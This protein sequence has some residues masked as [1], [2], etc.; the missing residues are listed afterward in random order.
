MR[1]EPVLSPANSMLHFAKYGAK[2]VLMWCPSCNEH[3]DEV[4]TKEQDV[5]FPYEHV[6]SFIAR[7]LDRV[8][9]VRRVERRVALHYHTGSAQSDLDWQNTRAI[10]RRRS[11]VST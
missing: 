3:Y 10:L 2:K 1:K 7:H 9:F 4:V 8:P 6:T 11:P 5:A